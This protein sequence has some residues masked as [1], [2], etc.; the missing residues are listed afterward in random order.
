MHAHIDAA[1]NT[2]RTLLFD[3]SDRQRKTWKRA[4]REREG[5]RDEKRIGGVRDRLA[6]DEGRILQSRIAVHM[7]ISRREI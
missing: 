7:R 6:H 3:V 5:V 1:L 4:L 2:S